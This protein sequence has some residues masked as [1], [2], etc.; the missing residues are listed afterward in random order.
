MSF[1]RS[2]LFR[3]VVSSLF[4]LLIVT[5]LNDTYRLNSST[6]PWMTYTRFYDSRSRQLSEYSHSRSHKKNKGY[7]RQEDQAAYEYMMREENRKIEERKRKSGDASRAYSMP[8][9]ISEEDVAREL[10]K[11][12]LTKLIN[13]FG[14]TINEKDMYTTFYHYHTYLQRRYSKM[15]IKL[16]KLCHKLASKRYIPDEDLNQYW[17]ECKKGVSRHLF[18]LNYYSY[19]HFFEFAKDAP[20][21]DMARFKT[22]LA[23]YVRMWKQ[24]IRENNKKWTQVLTKNIKKY[25][26]R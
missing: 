14:E 3:A 19:K 26:K 9:R 20:V 18:T 8:Y 10:S 11:K 5:I 16:Q 21:E 12:E 17:M 25:K 2:R 6:S 4:V 23:D 1:Q 22:F 24:K 13:S 15:I 7:Y